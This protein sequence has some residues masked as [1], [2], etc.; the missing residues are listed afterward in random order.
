MISIG[1]EGLP[2]AGNNYSL[3]CTAS[4][5]EKLVDTAVLTVSWA[6]AMGD[7]VS[8][9]GIDA[10]VIAETVN[11]TALSFRPLYTSHGGRYICRASLDIPELSTSVN[12]SIARDVFVESE[13]V[14]KL[15]GLVFNL[16]FTV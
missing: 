15:L 6:D 13:Y 4:V 7:V 2:T 3:I 8:E 9:D 1:S 5:L 11:T 14:V 16:H 10:T 12:T